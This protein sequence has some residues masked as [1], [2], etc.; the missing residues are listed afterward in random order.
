MINER[1]SFY[2]VSASLRGV[3]W[4]ARRAGRGVL[5]TQP[6][7]A[8]A[9]GV[10]LA[11]P[12]VLV[13]S[14]AAPVRAA[15]AAAVTPATAASVTISPTPAAA[16]AVACAAVADSVDGAVAVDVPLVSI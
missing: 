1:A 10:L 8:V 11:A 7:S 2:P 4:G 13:A 16:A 6:L 3:K 5:S 14:S 15:F 9:A 12:R